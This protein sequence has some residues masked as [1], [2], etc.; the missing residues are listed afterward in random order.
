M[1]VMLYM[2]S[3]L[4]FMGFCMSAALPGKVKALSEEVA[5]LR[6]LV[7]AGAASSAYPD[8]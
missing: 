2:W 4:G 6:A 1:E 8:K 7:Q 3:F 5:E